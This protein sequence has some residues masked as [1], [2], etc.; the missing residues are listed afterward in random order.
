[1]LL[2]R[3]IFVASTV[4]LILAIVGFKFH[5][6]EVIEEEAQNIQKQDIVQ[7]KRVYDDVKKQRIEIKQKIEIIES[8]VEKK[9]NGDKVK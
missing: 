3:T 6:D 2:K 4:L 5:N 8:V 1:M 7:M 9:T